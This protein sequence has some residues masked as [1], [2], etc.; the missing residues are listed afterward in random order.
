MATVGG[1]SPQ[2]KLEGFLRGL[3]DLFSPILED[4]DLSG[5]IV[6][7][8]GDSRDKIRKSFGESP[9]IVS[10]GTAGLK[11]GTDRFSRFGISAIAS[12]SPLGEGARLFP[13]NFCHAFGFSYRFVYPFARMPARFF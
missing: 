6:I 5:L 7:G 2:E 3:L 12:Y 13:Q 8:G 4:D 9:P 1:Q 10:A 11:N